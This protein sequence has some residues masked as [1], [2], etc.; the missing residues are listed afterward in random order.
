MAEKKRTPTEREYDLRRIADLYL[1]GQTQSSIASKLGITQQQ[2]SYDLTEIR[3]RWRTDTTINLDEAKQK[4][5]ARIDTLERTY[6][7]AWE[8]TLI[9]RT[10]TR[11]E[12][13]SVTGDVDKKDKAKA[14]GS[15]KAVIEKETLLGNPAY[16]AGVMSCIE[17]RC[18]LLGLDAPTKIAPTTPDGKETIP[19]AIVQPGLAKVLL[20][21]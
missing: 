6:W 16:L 21:D 20:D 2:V 12:Q 1:Q 4:E 14:K 3:S 11:T 5:L 7:D 19:I 10:K 18:K 9:E 15:A 13:S 17:R 8:H